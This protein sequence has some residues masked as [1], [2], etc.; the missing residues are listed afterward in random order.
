MRLAQRSANLTCAAEEILP[1]IDF[2]ALEEGK[3]FHYS[4]EATSR[5]GQYN[6]RPVEARTRR[7]VRWVQAWNFTVPAVAGRNKVWNFEATLGTH[8]LTGGSLGLVLVPV[9]ENASSSFDFNLACV[10]RGDCMLA[11]HL[12]QNL[13]S[14]RESLLAG[15]Y[16]LWLFDRVGERNASLVSCSPLSLEISVWPTD[17]KETLMNCDAARLPENLTDSDLLDDQGFLMYSQDVLLDI[18]AFQDQTAVR[19]TRPSVFR[20]YAGPHFVDIDLL[21]LDDTSRA[22]AWSVKSH[23]AEGLVYLLEPNREYTLLVQFFGQHSL[24]F[25]ETYLLQLAIAPLDRPAQETFCASVSPSTP[26]LSDLDAALASGASFDRDYGAFV[27]S[28]PSPEDYPRTLVHR[29]LLNIT[30]TTRLQVELLFDFLLG[31]LRMQVNSRGDAE[32]DY[33]MVGTIRGNRNRLNVELPPGDYTLGIFVAPLQ[34][35]NY[36]FS[37]LLP[38]CIEYALRVRAEPADRVQPSSCFGSLDLPASLNGPGFLS[39][40]SPYV[41]FQ[42]DFRLPFGTTPVLRSIPL[43]FTPHRRSFMRAFT[44]RNSD[45]DV[46]F[47][48][49]ANG[50]ILTRSRSWHQ[51]DEVAWIVDPQVEYQLQLLFYPPRVRLDPCATWSFEFA[52]APYEPPAS[53]PPCPEYLPT[54]LLARVDWRQEVNLQR[55]LRFYQNASALLRYS[56]P[57]TVPVPI[58]FRASVL[59]SFV[60]TTLVLAVGPAGGAPL[61]YGTNDYNA[62]LLPVQLLQP[63]NYTLRVFEPVQVETEVL[64]CA[65]FSLQVVAQVYSPETEDPEAFELCESFGFPDSFNQPAYLSPLSG[66]AMHFSQQFLIDVETARSVVPFRIDEPSLFRVYVP[67]HPEVDVDLYLFLERRSHVYS[68]VAYSN[69]VAEELLFVSLAPGQYLFEVHYLPLMGDDSGAGLPPASECAAHA[70]EIAVLPLS[71]L[72]LSPSV[73]VPCQDVRPPAAL[74]L[75]QRF[76][77]RNYQLSGASPEPVEIRFTVEDLASL[78]ADLGYAFAAGGLALSLRQDSLPGRPELPATLALNH[79]FMRSLLTRGNYTLRVYSP[80]VTS[81]DPIAANT[82]FLQCRFFELDALVNSTVT[83]EDCDYTE[84]LPT[85]LY[86]HAGGS[87]P[88]GGP[89]DPADGSVRISGERF[90]IRQGS[91]YHRIFFRVLVRSYMRVFASAGPGSDVDFYLYGGVNASTLYGFSLSNEPFESV[92]YDL[93]PSQYPYMLLIHFYR[94]PASSFCPYLQFELAMKPAER[95]GEELA[96]PV[97]PLPP[98]QAAPPQDLQLRPGGRLEISSSDYYFTR[99]VIEEYTSVIPGG[100]RTF[101]WPIHLELPSNSTV[102]A[103]VEFDFLAND[104]RLSLSADSGGLYVAGTPDVA[105][106][107]SSEYNFQNSLVA[108]TIAPGRYTLNLRERLRSAV[109]TPAEAYCHHFGFSLTLTTSSVAQPQVLGVYPPSGV[110][111]NPYSDLVLTISLSEPVDLTPAYLAQHQ[112]VSLWDQA[113][114][115]SIQPRAYSF[116]DQHVRLRVTFDKSNLRPNATYVLR[117]NA[118]RLQTHAGQPF[119]EYTAQHVY[120]FLSCDCSGHG[121]C[122]Q[123]PNATRLVCIC[124]ANYAGPDCSQC[125]AGYHGQGGVCVPNVACTPELCGQHGTCSDLD[126]YPVCTCDEGYATEGNAFCSRCAPGYDGYPNC[127]RTDEGEEESTRCHA[128]LLPDSLDT[129]A[130]LGNSTH[131]HLADDYYIDMV[132]RSHRTEF[133]LRADSVLRVYAEPHQLD[134]DLWLWR[135][136][137]DGSQGDEVAR[138]IAWNREEEIFVFLSGSPDSPQRY[139]LTFRYYNWR[140]VPLSE[141]ENFRMELAIEP[142]Q[143]LRDEAAAAVAAGLCTGALP[144]PGPAGQR[145][146]PETGLSYAPAQQVFSVPAQASLE[147]DDP[148]WF[149]SY[150]FN[151]PEQPG[152]RAVLRAEALFR[153]L[154]G[155]L[156]LLLEQSPAETAQHCGPL[157]ADGNNG[158]CVAGRNYMNRNLLESQLAPGNYTLW[159]YEPTPQNVS[160]TTCS[161]FQFALSIEYEDRSDTDIFHCTEASPIPLRLETS[162]G[163]IHLA[164]HYLTT[165]FDEIVFELREVS[166]LRAAL[167]SRE[168][169][170]TLMLSAPNGSAIAV[171]STFAGEPYLFKEGLQPGEYRLVVIGWSALFEQS[172][173]PMVNLEF[174]VAP[175]ARQ[176][177][178]TCADLPQAD[179]LDDAHLPELPRVLPVPYRFPNPSEYYYYYYRLD[180]LPPE[181]QAE[182]GGVRTLASYQFT[183]TQTARLRASVTSDFLSANTM[184]ELSPA[185]ADP[186]A[187]RNRFNHNHLL[188]DL[189]PGSYVLS[190]VAPRPSLSCVLFQFD[191]ALEP[192]P[193]FDEDAAV[194]QCA[195]AEPVPNS[196]DSL[197]FLGS[198]DT[199]NYQ[200]DRLRVDLAGERATR[201]VTFT[202]HVDSLLR[203]FAQPDPTLETHVSVYRDGRLMSTT[204]TTGPALSVQLQR[205]H[206]Y[207]LRLQVQALVAGGPAC[208]LLNLEFDI[209]RADEAPPSAS[210]P[211][212]LPAHW[213]PAPPATGLFASPRVYHYDSDA[214]KEDLFFKQQPTGTPVSRTYQFQLHERARI[215]A[216]L[217]FDFT[218]T[219]M[220]IELRLNGGRDGVWTGREM[221]NRNVLLQRGLPPGVYSLVLSEAQDSTD[222]AGAAYCVHFSFKLM[223][224]PDPDEQAL[225]DLSV[226]HLPA[227]FD[228]LAYLGYNGRMHLQSRFRLWEDQSNTANV[229]FTLGEPALLRVVTDTP[230]YGPAATLRVSVPSAPAPLN[231]PREGALLVRLPPGRHSLVF[232][233]DVWIADELVTGVEIAIEPIAHLQAEL[234][235]GGR[236]LCEPAPVAIPDLVRVSASG[237]YHWSD[238]WIALPSPYS[239]ATVKQL[240]FLLDRKS[241]VYASVGYSAPLGALAIRLEPYYNASGSLFYSSVGLNMQSL[242]AVVPPGPTRL[243][244]YQPSLFPASLLAELPHCDYFSFTLIISDEASSSSLVDCSNYNLLPWDLND[245]TGGSVPYGGPITAGYLNI[246]E[247]DFL[248]PADAETERVNLTLSRTS[249]ASVYFASAVPSGT[250]SILP[251]L[252]LPALN[253]TIEPVYSHVDLANHL[254]AYVIVPGQEPA[255]T[256]MQFEFTYRTIYTATSC[257]YYQMALVIESLSDLETSLSCPSP[258]PAQLPSAR[259]LPDQRHIIEEYVAGS[260]EVQRRSSA[261]PQLPDLYVNFTL[262]VDSSLDASFAFNS[263]YASFELALLTADGMLV[264]SAQLSPETIRTLP[265]DVVQRL[266][267]PILSAGSYSLRLRR[268]LYQ[269]LPWT[270]VRLCVPY[271]FYVLAGPRSGAPYVLV[272]PPGAINLSPEDDLVLQVWLSTAPYTSLHQ[273]LLPTSPEARSAFVLLNPSTMKTSQPDDV[274]MSDDRLRWRLVFSRTQLQ[275]NTT[276]YLMLGSPNRLYDS[277]LTPFVQPSTNRYSTG[278]RGCNNHGDLVH[279]ICRCYEGYQGLSC[280]RC[281]PGYH[282]AVDPHSGASYCTPDRSSGLCAPDNTS[283]GCVPGSNPCEPL[284]VCHDERGRLECTCTYSQHMA[285][286]QCQDC[287][288][289]YHSWPHCLPCPACRAGSCSKQNGTC[290]CNAGWAGELCD[291]CAPGWQGDACDQP[292]PGE[293]RILGMPRRVAIAIGIVL[294]VLIVA[295]L[296]AIGVFY[297]RLR[298]QYRY[299][300]LT[301]IEMEDDHYW[302]PSRSS[303]QRPSDGDAESNLLSSQNEKKSDQIF[304]L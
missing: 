69:G 21:L 106:D 300:R 227:S 79:A 122:A 257:R 204:T 52:I 117:V 254:E 74:A 269:G 195:R 303:K 260:F 112:V 248:A 234:G 38:S 187:G 135:L 168:H 225:V 71:Q 284:G 164:D 161:P 162:A 232:S 24:G 200:S 223:L 4:S 193:T 17:E 247:P 194:Q 265:Y 1:S 228:S 291:R 174:A 42:D 140:S 224:E 253:R 290:L 217:E 58:L 68:A 198:D 206:A 210:C 34:S 93:E 245:P 182:D 133:T 146:D 278:L 256:H 271:E 160:L 45:V 51:E 26:D 177:A 111:L 213:P 89:Q 105:E 43:R 73:T 129:P 183:L 77:E 273:P 91:A 63:G 72:A 15:Q 125:A 157:G 107:S 83:Q 240:S 126:G 121:H 127:V 294:I 48:L 179:R 154:P 142:V 258:L 28:V 279:G 120:S 19:V 59:F 216:E 55:E 296:V 186:I 78:R 176:P 236:A 10:V 165:G 180:T 274:Q 95:V 53:P 251:R 136:K 192:L 301:D 209:V 50:R 169:D 149:W 185:G 9:N 229:S 144:Q 130:Y 124:D 141:C 222:A 285:G 286:D 85:D 239:L 166:S 101:T 113:R 231:A 100:D 226:P 173:C 293:P 241:V 264:Q 167:H 304:E 29:L 98:D 299:G 261:M 159:L 262:S 244:L 156:G 132:H 88:Y 86:T 60:D 16:T 267:R 118:G 30:R 18:D 171:A 44:D 47:Y 277:T 237:Y 57:F 104:F 292:V 11:L 282:L 6:V 249:L 155:H 8:F 235:A 54:D 123:D 115:I 289:G 243:T 189:S 76:S 5:V 233:V 33:H 218:W 220:E 110:G 215:F 207:E 143:K 297:W 170:V 298:R 87:E 295:G 41:H 12:R 114:E 252:R 147:S 64:V 255:T 259:L 109:S 281:A 219:R 23:G 56:V 14:I 116:D 81:A 40:L 283:C 276:Y 270:A 203:F 61:A 287:A 178:R 35:N 27:F 163:R 214:T 75:D 266:H 94:L 175:V 134:I 181:E 263:L 65:E 13:Q 268:T 202:P 242:H 137:Q 67:P 275:P 108:H 153:F 184:L 208:R 131:L 196:L 7:D 102:S 25:C 221:R 128:V 96:C 3:E 201:S 211:T 20:A 172:N 205:G 151:V 92:L 145:I 152:K 230:S 188:E 49:W 70:A 190:L 66:F 197:R 238:D 103:F 46:D 250:L 99:S 62:N 32:E 272:Q 80:V 150:S 84:Q 36:D 288:P 39:P 199:F 212:E 139:R 2:S 97:N 31:A 138:S 22:V 246:Y 82:S 90:L 158:R 302:D 119:A 280:E 148:H 37:S 191:L